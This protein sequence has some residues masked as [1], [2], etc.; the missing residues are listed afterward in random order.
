MAFAEQFEQRLV[1]QGE[2]RRS[3][4]ETIDIGWRLLDT[5]PRED[6]LRLSEE[7]WNARHP[8]A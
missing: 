1:A 8:R 7:T 4:A 2:A 5:L 6:L 3:L